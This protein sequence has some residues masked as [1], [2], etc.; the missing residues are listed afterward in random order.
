MT[1]R[2]TM[3]IAII[4]GSILSCVKAL[5]ENERSWNP[6]TEKEEIIFESSEKVLDT[7]VINKIVENAVSDGPTP[8]LHRHT[9]LFVY[10]KELKSKQSYFSEKRIL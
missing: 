6:Y 9:S 2:K 5:K 10:G 3:L 1:I 8:K 4:M 7:I